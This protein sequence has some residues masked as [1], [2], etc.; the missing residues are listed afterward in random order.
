MGKGIGDIN[1]V[2]ICEN[3]S[4]RAPSSPHRIGSAPP[5][6]LLF[7]LKKNKQVHA[8]AVYETARIADKCEFR[9]SAAQMPADASRPRRG[10][11]H[12][13]DP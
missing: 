2:P 11:A 7:L 13:C 10:A 12:S 5:A 1:N 3:T 6:R 4:D 9:N 8:I